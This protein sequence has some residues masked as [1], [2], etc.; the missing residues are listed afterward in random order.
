MTLADEA[1]IEAVGAVG[2]AQRLGVVPMALYKHVANKEQ[3]LDGIVDVVVR[4]RPA[5]SHPGLE[6]GF[7][8][9]DPVGP[10]GAIAAPLGAASKSSTKAT[11]T[12]VVLDYIGPAIQPF[13][14]PGAYRLTSPTCPARVWE[15]RS[16]TRPGL[17]TTGGGAARCA[18]SH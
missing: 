11:P 10:C 18:R 1:G 7:A 6:A 3:L 17:P 12:P 13:S 16:G 5:G 4:D 15:A 2:L 9:A 14:W 8:G